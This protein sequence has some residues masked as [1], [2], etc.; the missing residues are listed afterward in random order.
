MIVS[1]KKQLSA[2]LGAEESLQG[3]RPAPASAVSPIFDQAFNEVAVL[4]M[5]KFRLQ[6]I[7]NIASILAEFPTG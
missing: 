1:S 4:T 6:N 2:I 5:N 3:P 7:R